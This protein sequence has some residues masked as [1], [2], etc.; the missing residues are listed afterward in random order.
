MT[1]LPALLA[2]GILNDPALLFCL[3]IAGVLIVVFVLRRRAAMR[4]KSRN[5]SS[6]RD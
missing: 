6:T 2:D 5:E 4:K 1:F 3:F